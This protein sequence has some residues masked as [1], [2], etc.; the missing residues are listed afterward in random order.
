VHAPIGLRNIIAETVGWRGGAL[1]L[2]V[3]AIGV[4]LALGGARAVWAVF[5]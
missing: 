5:A 1:D 2:T 4:G 3:L